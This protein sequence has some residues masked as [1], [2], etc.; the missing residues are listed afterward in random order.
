[1]LTLKAMK[2]V[3]GHNIIILW[4]KLNIRIGLCSWIQGKIKLNIS[5][6]LLSHTGVEDNI[7]FFNWDWAVL[8]TLD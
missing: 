2:P 6:V 4:P 5:E 3:S 1:M 8:E 7:K